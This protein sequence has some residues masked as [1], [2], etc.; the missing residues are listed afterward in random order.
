MLEHTGEDSCRPLGLRRVSSGIQCRC[1]VA[2]ESK[3]AESAGGHALEVRGFPHAASSVIARKEKRK[4][5]SLRPT[6]IV[7]LLLPHHSR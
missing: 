5:P 4:C 7:S 6:S 2:R 3:E 1:T